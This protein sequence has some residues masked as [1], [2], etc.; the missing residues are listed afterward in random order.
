M[1]SDVVTGETMIVIEN[2]NKHF[3]SGDALSRVLRDIN[4]EIKTGE[5][6]ILKGVSGSGKTTLLSI[7]A[8]LDRPSSGKVL[9]EGES[10]SKLPDLHISHFRAQKI[11]MIFQHF[12][13]FD[14]L[15]AAENVMIPLIPAGLNMNEVNRRVQAS[16]K[17]A[18]ISHKA[19]S[20]AG[21]LSGGE[22]QR[23]AIA[24]ALASD[25]AIILCD[26]PTANLDRDNSLKF[27]DILSQLHDMR[28][29]IVVATH[30]PLFDTLPFSSRVVPMEDGSLVDSASKDTLVEC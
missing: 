21:R 18:N 12:N 27:I 1:I 4:L 9:V 19:Q 17:L 14:H 5:C 28:K 7:M 24:R 3:E 20:P 23:V 26:E 16:L 30:D 10:I 29:T 6:I 15:T 11:G 13:L 8:G 22:K 2:L 25:P